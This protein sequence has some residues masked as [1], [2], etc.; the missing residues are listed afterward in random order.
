MR[1]CTEFVFLG[2]GL[3][4][5]VRVCWFKYGLQRFTAVVILPTCDQYYLRTP[6]SLF[7]GP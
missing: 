3:L 1:G 4:K 5:V 6:D 7:S 2:F